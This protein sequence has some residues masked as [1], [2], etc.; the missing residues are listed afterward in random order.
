MQTLSGNMP[1]LVTFNVFEP[2]YFDILSTSVGM[3]FQEW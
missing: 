2:I 3:K 1:D